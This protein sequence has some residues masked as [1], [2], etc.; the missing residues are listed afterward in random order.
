M[1][2]RKFR[3][4]AWATVLVQAG[5]AASAQ[6]QI[7]APLAAPVPAIQASLPSAS[8]V[9]AFYAKWSAPIWFRGPVA[10]PAAARLVAILKRAPFDG[11]GAGPQL[12]SLVEGAIARAASGK[13]ADVTAA[14]QTLSSAWVLYV[15]SLRRPA[16]RTIYAYPNLLPQNT[17]ADQ[18][19][20]TAAA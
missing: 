11:L 19:L 3:S 12:A 4:I 18:I 10:N 8:A 13:P 7:A 15:Q 1:N 5:V 17:R 20:L 2:A 14:E 9:S 6:A 16:P